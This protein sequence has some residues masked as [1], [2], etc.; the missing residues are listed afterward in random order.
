MLENELVK[1]LENKEILFI[2]NDL[3][4]YDN[5]EILENFLIE[6][7]LKYRTILNAS[8]QSFEC[9]SEIINMHDVIIWQST[10]LSETSIELVGCINSDLFTSKTLIELPLHKRSIFGKRTNKTKHKVYTLD[11]SEYIEDWELRNLNNV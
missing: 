2:E 3:G 7:K 11:V 9:L 1:L 4:L 10:Y 5:V 6:N 8:K